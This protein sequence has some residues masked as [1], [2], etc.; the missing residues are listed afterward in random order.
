[1]PTIPETLKRLATTFTLRDIMTPTSMLIC[2]SDEL[3]AP[4]VSANHPDFDVIPIK[5]GAG[6][7]GYY[8]RASGTTSHVTLSDVISDGTNLLDF[9]DFC[10]QKPFFFVLGDREITGYVHF[11]DLNHHLVKLTFYVILESLEKKALELVPSGDEQTYLRRNLNPSRMK[12]I[13][14]RYNDAGQAAR[15][16]LSYLNIADIL[17]LAQS[18]GCIGVTEDDIGEIKRVRNGAA[19]AIANLVSSYEDVAKLAAVKAECLR[20][21]EALGTDL[22][23]R[24]S[25]LYTA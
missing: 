20:L 14:K 17:R 12:Q 11:S 24:P 9:V 8:C 5:T 22:V 16:L 1:M 18:A 2:A 19:H 4:T 6:V 7:T 3:S 13:E 23:R 10:Q 25:A 15:S 21:D